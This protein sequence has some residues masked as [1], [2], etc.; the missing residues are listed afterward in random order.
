VNFR[1]QGLDAAAHDFRKAGVLS[2]FL[3]ADAVIHQELGGAASGQ[4]LDAAFLQFACE[5]DD[6]GLIGD[7]E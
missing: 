6:A 7:A 3:H 2:H 1:V 5:L 4:N